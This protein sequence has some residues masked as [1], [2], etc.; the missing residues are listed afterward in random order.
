ME[1]Q[2]LRLRIVVF[3]EDDLVCAQCLEYDIAAQ[4]K[5]LED[6]LY[7][8]SRLVVG[9][10]AIAAENEVTPFQ[11]IPSAPQRFV[12]WFERSKIPLP[13]VSAPFTPV[14]ASSVVIQPAEIRVAQ[15]QAA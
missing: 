9:H 5:T 15:P 11:G 10:L 7:E 13:T 1:R 4:A 2:D 12:D 14:A 8:V 6:C 3:Q